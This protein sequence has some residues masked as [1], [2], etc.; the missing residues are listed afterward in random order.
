M[1]PTTRRTAMRATVLA[2]IIPRPLRCSN[3]PHVKIS[4]LL[5]TN[6]CR[7]GRFFRGA[8]RREAVLT[9][10][11]PEPTPCGLSDTIANGSQTH[12]WLR[13]HS[14]DRGGSWGWTAGFR[15]GGMAEWSM[16]VVLKTTV[17]ER[18]PGVRIPL[19]PPFSEENVDTIRPRRCETRTAQCSRRHRR[20]RQRS[21]A[22][23]VRSMFEGAVHCL[24]A[25][26]AEARFRLRIDYHKV[27]L[28]QS[29][30]GRGR[31]DPDLR[32]GLGRS[33]SGRCAE[34]HDAAR[35]RDS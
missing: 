20:L 28:W 26:E 3:L 7:Y 35:P 4:A 25:Q 8:L 33:V 5:Y 16:A 13:T 1:R 27:K 31:Q 6:R 14:R 32:N 23:F 24:P 2:F 34:E 11:P 30:P 15:R 12:I 19:P 22:R 9:P 10:K 17:P 21:A 18:V 29:L